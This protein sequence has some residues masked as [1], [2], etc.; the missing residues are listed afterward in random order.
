MKQ[1]AQAT[2]ELKL[3]LES[4][5]LDFT[6]HPGTIIL[7]PNQLSHVDD[8]IFLSRSEK[9]NQPTSMEVNTDSWGP[10]RD[11]SLAGQMKLPRGRKLV[12]K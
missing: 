7:K 4:H 1:T 2:A 5:S 8:Y 11:I 10:K 3:L 6:H 12:T 9:H